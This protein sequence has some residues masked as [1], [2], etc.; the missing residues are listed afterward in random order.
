MFSAIS[1]SLSL[2]LALQA[3]AAPPFRNDLNEHQP[4]NISAADLK[5]TLPLSPG[6]TAERANSIHVKRDTFV[7]GPGICGDVPFWPTGTLGNSTTQTDFEKFTAEG[8]PVKTAVF[9]DQDIALTA[10]TAAGG[11]KQLSDYE[12]LYQDQWKKSIPDG[13]DLGVLSNYT[14]D[15]LFSMERLSINPYSTKRLNPSDTLPFPVEDNIATAI[16]GATV[17]LLLKSGR[18][19]YADHSNQKTLESTGRYAAA[20]DAYFY[21]HPT[22]GDFLPLAVRT[23]VGSN[24]VYTPTDSANDWLL[25][26]MMFNLNDFW[27]SQWYHLSATHNVAEIVFEAA[28]RTLSDE[29]PVMAILQ[30]LTPELF[31]YRQSAI[32]VLVNKG[33]FIDRLFAFSGAAAIKT[34]SDMYTSGFAGNFQANYFYPNLRSRGLLDSTFGPEIKAFPFLE[35]ASVIHTAI[36]DFMT[37]FVDSTYPDPSVFTQDKELQAWIVEAVA[38]K[39]MDFPTSIDRTTLID[40]L[41]HFAFLVSAEHQTLNTNDLAEASGSLPFHPFAL[42]QPIPTAKG[43]TDLVP[44]LPNASQAVSQIVLTALFARPE[45][46]KSDRSL[47]QMFNDPAMLRGM[48]KKTA[49]AAAKFQTTLMRFSDVVSSRGFDAEGLCQGMPFIWRTLDPQ[50]A[51]YFLTI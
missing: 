16:T 34:T 9:S 22:S 29:H 49:E 25:A 50:R 19:F 39:V 18:L 20:C 41:T 28:Y 15:L 48:N 4:R 26:K 37:A 10:I 46:V 33:G 5:Y 30:R 32:S 1:W 7:Y 24:L 27:H 38:A 11:I 40:I 45:W 44:F 8:V 2:G 43:V 47:T 31:S 23:N 13:V 12:L 6:N 42:Y 14:D 51:P 35:D 3:A 36:K 21:I 17:E